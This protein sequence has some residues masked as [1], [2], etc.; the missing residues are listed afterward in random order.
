MP[1]ESDQRV[2][3]KK[4]L[5]R[6]ELLSEFRFDRQWY[7]VCLIGHV[8]FVGQQNRVFLE[9]ERVPRF[10]QPALRAVAV[11][12]EQDPDLWVTIRFAGSA[13]AS[14]A[15]RMTSCGGKE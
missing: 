12:V 8:E 14:L 6:K 4:E 15:G 11:E 13:P 2:Q 3:F 10:S 7:K 5:K 1:R 9:T